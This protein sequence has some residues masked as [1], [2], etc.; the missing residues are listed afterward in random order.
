METLRKIAP[1]A[2]LGVL[3]ITLTL[4]VMVLSPSGGSFAFD[5]HHELYPQAKLMLSGE[6][7]YPPSGSDLSDGTN[8]VWPPFAVLV[9]AP[10]TLLPIGIADTIATL[11]VIASLGGA[12]WV[13]GIRDWRIYGVTLLWPPVINAYQTANATLPLCLLCA[14]AWRYR[15]RTV[16]PGLLVGAALAAKFFLWPLVLWLAAI[17]RYKA[18]ATAAVVAALS[19]LLIV[20][21]VSL[22]DYFSLIANLSRT[23]DQDTYTIYAL[24]TE[25]G[26]PSEAARGATLALG[27]AILVLAWRRQSLAL[28]IGAALILSP[29]VWLHFLALLVVP[30][31][32]AYPKFNAK[33]LLPLPLWLVVGTL[34]GAWWQTTLTLAVLLSMIVV[35]ERAGVHEAGGPAER[36]PRPAARVGTA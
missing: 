23:F 21:F 6:N 18:A 17:R 34:N 24:L 15:R 29:V 36:A 26:V 13:V 9:A 22:H 1:M 8:F 33:W 32:L 28:A 30:F 3:P 20:P 4:A 27:G 10:L 19:L 14:L 5:F 35:C 12:L 2:L 25:A 7:P 11:L 31:A 16:L